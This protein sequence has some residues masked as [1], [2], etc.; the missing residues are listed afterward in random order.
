MD[1]KRTTIALILLSWLVLIPAWGLGPSD[2]AKKVDTPPHEDVL[3][4]LPRVCLL[5]KCKNHLADTEYE[6][7]CQCLLWDN[8]DGV[9]PEPPLVKAALAFAETWKLVI[10]SF[11]LIFAFVAFQCACCLCVGRALNPCTG[12]CCCCCCQLCPCCARNRWNEPTPQS[13]AQDKAKTE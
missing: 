2:P 1:P 11:V 6:R 13:S 8:S 3:I 5:Q 10:V 9:L 7:E 12:G 4:E